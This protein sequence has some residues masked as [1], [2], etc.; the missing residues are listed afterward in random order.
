MK[1]HGSLAAVLALL[2]IAVL[3]FRPIGLDAIDAPFGSHH[4]AEVQLAHA[5]GSPHCALL[6]DCETVSI[7]NAGINLGQ[8]GMVLLLSGLVLT[9]ALP[10]RLT[11]RS[12]K[13]LV[14]NPPP[15]SIPS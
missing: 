1:R 9:V 8:T 13:A 4:S 10:Q 5:E 6:A 11:G 15:L 14:P 3:V 12:W 2:A 7:S